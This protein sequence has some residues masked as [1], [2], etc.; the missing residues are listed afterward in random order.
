MN[1]HNFD[2][3]IEKE[4]NLFFSL[5]SLED[6][7]R[8][9]MEIPMSFHDFLRISCILFYM[10]FNYYE[11]HINELFPELYRQKEHML[12]RHN[13][14]MLEYPNYYKDEGVDEK[15]RNWLTEFCGQIKDKTKQRTCRKKLES[16]LGKH[17]DP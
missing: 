16:H 2:L 17:N 4:Q 8:L 1:K 3:E 5:C 12:M 6:R 14:I 11:T 7:Q 9:N 10:D 15:I 13:E